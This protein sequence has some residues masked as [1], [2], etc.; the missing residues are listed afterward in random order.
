MRAP[1]HN[2]FG[3]VFFLNIAKVYKSS[4][5]LLN[6]VFSESQNIGRDV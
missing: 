5:L 2:R 1:Q 6:D 3:L 4:V